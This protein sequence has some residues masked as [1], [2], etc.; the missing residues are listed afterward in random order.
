MKKTVLFLT[1]TSSV[2]FAT[3]KSKDITP[4]DIEQL[5]LHSSQHAV[6][7]VQRTALLKIP[8]LDVDCSNGVF[9]SLADDHEAYSTLLAAVVSKSNVRLGLETTKKTPWGDARYC[10][11]TYFDIKN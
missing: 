10:A 7:S 3:E 6:G 2:C 1:L 4:S 5:R 11:L 8:N 9:I